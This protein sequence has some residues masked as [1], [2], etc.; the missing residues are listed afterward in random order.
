MP[1]RLRLRAKASASRSWSRVVVRISK[2]KRP[3]A[4]AMDQLRALERVAGLREQGEAR[5]SLA[6][7]RPEPSVTGGDQVP[8]MMS[9]RTAPGNGASSSRSRAFGR[10]AVRRQFAAVEIAGGALV[11]IE[12]IIVVDPFEVE[13]MQDRL[14]HADIG[15]DRPAR[16]EHEPVHALGQAVGE[17]LLDHAAVAQRRK[18]VGGLPAA[19]IGFRAHVVKAFLERLEM[20]VAVAVIVEADGVEIPQAAIDRQVAAPII[21][22]ALEG[23]ALARLSLR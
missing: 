19:G 22:I 20:R 16:V 7:S 18:I 2:P 13:Q 12:E 1:A 23:D 11:E 9:A 6:R 8:S 21:R 14:A 15:E 3:A 4:G 10:H 17:C 5:R